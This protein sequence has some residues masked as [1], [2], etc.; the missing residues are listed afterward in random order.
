ML[1]FYPQFLTNK[2]VGILPTL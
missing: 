1:K 2:I